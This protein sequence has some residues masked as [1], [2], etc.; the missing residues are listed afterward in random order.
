MPVEPGG[1]IHDEHP[2]A[3]P[4]ADRDP[5]RRFRGRLTAPVTLWTAVDPDRGRRRGLTVA[6]TLVVDGDPGR[7]MGLVDPESDLG[8]ALAG[9]APFVVALLA[10]RHRLL[11]DRFAG[12]APAPG[13]L[14]AQDDWHDEEWGP[15]LADAP[16]WLGCRTDE[17][18][19]LGYALRVTGTVQRVELA[20]DEPTLT[21]RRGRYL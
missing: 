11:A 2:F 4:A 10:D 15:V 6:S 3:T 7:L 17:T 21:F 18:A 20:D 19:P 8:E 12:Q 9:G 5:L 1:E 13:G 16:G 14:F